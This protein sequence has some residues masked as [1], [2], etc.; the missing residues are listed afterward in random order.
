MTIEEYSEF[1]NTTLSKRV[2]QRGPSSVVCD[3][4]P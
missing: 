2:P 3:N 4:N 1:F